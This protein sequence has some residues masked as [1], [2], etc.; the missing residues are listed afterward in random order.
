MYAAFKWPVMPPGTT[1]AARVRR[2]VSMGV[3]ASDSGAVGTVELRVV[4]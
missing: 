2:A 4:R 1:R 3:A